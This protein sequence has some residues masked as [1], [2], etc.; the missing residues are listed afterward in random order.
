LRPP[1]PPRRSAQSPCAA[2]AKTKP[3]GESQP[4]ID[5]PRRGG[6]IGRPASFISAVRERRLVAI[7]TSLRGFLPF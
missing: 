3:A 1:L 2:G 4:G 7:A 6:R 5:G